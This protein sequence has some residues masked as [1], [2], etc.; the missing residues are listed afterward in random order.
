MCCLFQLSCSHLVS[1]PSG[2]ESS[3]ACGPGEIKLGIGEAWNLKAVEAV[4]K[5]AAPNRHTNKFSNV[6]RVNKKGKLV[7]GTFSEAKA[8]GAVMAIQVTCADLTKEK[9]RRTHAFF[10]GP[11]DAWVDP[12]W[13]KKKKLKPLYILIWIIRTSV[14]KGKCWEVIEVH[15]KTVIEFFVTFT[16]LGVDQYDYK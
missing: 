4:F 8:G 5:Y 2:N 12:S 9:R 11:C 10:D 7:M 15:G 16:Q 13:K 1:V 14:A 3:I 6:P